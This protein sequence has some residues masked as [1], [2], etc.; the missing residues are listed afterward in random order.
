MAYTIIKTDGNILTTIAD[1][2]INTSSTSLGLPG[3]NYAGYGNVLDTNFVRLLENFAFSDVPSNPIR[4]QLWCDTT[5]T[6][7][8]L[9]MCPSDGE[10]NASNWVVLSS[11][12]SGN[13]NF[14]N[15]SASGT[16]TIGAN[17]GVANTITTDNIVANTATINANLAV[18]NIS[19]TTANLAK[20][21]TG[22][23]NTI[24]GNATIN[25]NWTITSS[26]TFNA[27]LLFANAN[28][29]I[30][31]DNYMYGNGQPFNPAGTYSNSNV[32]SYIVTYNGNVGGGTATFSGTTLSA[33]ANTTAGTITG[34]WT[35]SAG[36]RLNSTYADLAERFEADTYYE[37]GTV[38]ELGGEKEITVAKEEL[39]ESVFGVISNTAGYVMNGMAGSDETHPPVAVTGRVF[40]K[41]K[42]K[43]KKNDRLVSA[44]KGY[45]RAA[46]K[47]EVTPF[48]TIGRALAN[49]EDSGLG[50]VEAIVILR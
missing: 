19:V 16:A 39:S 41:V 22:N 28:V 30:R 31:C 35:L 33:G 10:L 9:R 2:T 37:P 48:N 47:H 3:R 45:A 17:L 44:G 29:G 25:G 46:Q 42:G 14:G 12:N 5:T 32:A 34:N 7:P 20:I 6:P 11:I 13:S 43:V 1:G 21:F 38:V 15:I 40:V 18:A 36:S 26:P 49:K 50:T 27:N 4:G 24:S 8:V 23:V